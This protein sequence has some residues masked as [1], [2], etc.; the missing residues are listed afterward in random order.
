MYVPEKNNDI[1]VP[2]KK[3]DLTELFVEIR[4]VAHS[5]FVRRPLCVSENLSQNDFLFTA[6]ISLAVFLT[7]KMRVFLKVPS[8]DEGQRTKKSYGS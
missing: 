6:N 7:E 4:G 5:R 1:R 3:V 8:W 2:E